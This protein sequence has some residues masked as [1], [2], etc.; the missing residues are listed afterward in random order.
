MFIAKHKNL[1]SFQSHLNQGYKSSCYFRMWK[2]Q[3]SESLTPEPTFSTVGYCPRLVNHTTYPDNSIFKEAALLQSFLKGKLRQPCCVQSTQPI[4]WWTT[5]DWTRA[6]Q[7][8]QVYIFCRLDIGPCCGQSQRS[9]K[10]TWYF[11]AEPPSESLSKETKNT[12]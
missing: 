3:I 12:K 10:E 4:P 5:G 1:G 9:A 2:L 7:Y 6:R 11:T 8:T